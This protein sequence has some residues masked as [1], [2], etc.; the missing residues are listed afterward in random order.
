MAYGVISEVRRLTGSPSSST[1]I[2][3][4]QISDQ[5]TSADSEIN[6][7]TGKFDW[8]TTDYG[9]AM[10]QEA[11]NFLAAYNVII[12]WDPDNLD[13]AREYRKRGKDLITELLGGNIPT[14]NPLRIIGVKSYTTH[15]YDTMNI[16][17]FLSDY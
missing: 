9:Y 13:K 5:I 1:V 2:T 8:A 12:A 15:Y 7:T 4:Q 14:G 17:G 3:D 10:I 16:D 11:S 6:V